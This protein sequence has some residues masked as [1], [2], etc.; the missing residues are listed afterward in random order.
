MRRAATVA[1]GALLG[2]LIALAL[3]APLL[4]SRIGIEQHVE[5]AVLNATGHMARVDGPATLHWFPRPS[6]SLG[7]ILVAGGDGSAQPLLSAERLTARFAL[8]PLLAGRLR[9]VSAEFDGLAAALRVDAN[10]RGN[11]QPTAFPLQP[12]SVQSGTRPPRIG[13]LPIRPGWS[14]NIRD[15]QA[16]LSYSTPSDG[17]TWD[18]FALDAG[19]RDRGGDARLDARL[20]V[21][22]SAPTLHGELR[23]D[24]AIEPPSAETGQLEVSALQVRGSD[25]VI[26]GGRGLDLALDTR[27]SYRIADGAWTIPSLTLAAGG[28]QVDATLQRHR[29]AAGPTIEGAFRLAGL[30]LRTWLQ[31]HGYGPVP[32]GPNTLRCTAAKGRFALTP[33]A[34]KI[35]PSA[36]HVDTASGVGQAQIGLGPTTAAAIALRIDQID[37]DPYLGQLRA[38]GQVSETVAQTSC[39]PPI[40]D[41][42]PLPALPELP[43]GA[44]LIARIEATVLHLGGL[45]YGQLLLDAHRQG[46]ISDAEIQ[47]DDFYSGHLQARIE[48]DERDAAAPR[49]TLRATAGAVDVAAL[50]RDLQGS[51]PLSGQGDIRAELAASGVDVAAMRSDLSGTL[52]VSVHDGQVSGLDLDALLA[53]VGANAADA[54]LLTEFSTLSATATGSSGVF[55]SNDIA[56]VT[57]MLK[58]SGNGQFNVVTETLALDL[59]AVLVEPPDGRR[60]RGLAGIRVP[61]TASGSWQQPRWRVDLGPALGEGARRLLQQQLNGRGNVLKQLEDRTG[62]KGLEQGLRG[63]LGF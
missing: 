4:V 42:D 49:H 2:A 11:W 56:G 33:G 28:L 44:D 43:D 25:L 1:L 59:Q 5:A 35:G 17:L 31:T 6:I 21:D 40:V 54:A 52:S 63:L 60:L 18:L 19:A 36:W 58:L 16:V 23:L 14:L 10:G 37:L 30:D 13:L 57:P 15:A 45:R 27:A 29:T 51:A 55:H 41:S 8:L 46:G 12:G 53:A 20:T 26:G 48:R 34:L 61:M 32:G 62:I 38:A 7:P 24:A 9:L 3:A 47:S 39:E 50:L 22:G